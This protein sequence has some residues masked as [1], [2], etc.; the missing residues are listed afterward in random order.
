MTDTYGPKP[1][2]F[3]LEDGG[4]R[5]Y[6]GAEVGNYLKFHRGTLYKKYPLLWKRVA[7]MEERERIR[8]INASPAFLNTNIML[9]KQTE[10]DE[11]L[12]GNDEKYRVPGGQSTPRTEGGFTPL[13]PN[14]PKA[15][16]TSGW[17]GQQVT[18]GSH[19]LESVPA[20]HPSA[21]GRGKFKTKDSIYSTE[22][23]EQARKLLDNADK[24]EDLIPIRLDM[25][26]DGIKLRDTFCY[27]RNEHL[28][29][30]DIVAEQM[31]EDLDLP[32]SSF[33]PAIA[34][35]IFQ[36]IE[37]SEEPVQIDS[38][39]ADQ[40]AVLKL[41]INVG[42]QNLVDQFEWD[43]SEQSNNP[44]DFARVLCAELGLGGEFRATI[45]YS[46]RGQLNWNQKT[47]AFSESPLPTV[48]CPFRN[49][50][51]CE[52][53]GPFLETLTDAEIEKKMRDQDRNTRRMRRLVG[54][55]NPF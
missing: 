18:T 34:A 21:H 43:M 8:N 15:A 27:N 32:Q 46:I 55:Y 9:V 17:I 22:D 31:C 42:N 25:E 29:T 30:P 51:D 49:P 20:S 19:H 7:T 35:A 4:E 36:Q 26:I 11:M 39:T 53:W 47:F 2:S 38:Q 33:Q 14:P 23:L 10:V 13:K 50:S 5:Y 28:I 3:D 52:Q 41:N 44:E 16:P 24:P 45:C 37:T 40:R 12:S 48:D 1:Q 54:N 6:I